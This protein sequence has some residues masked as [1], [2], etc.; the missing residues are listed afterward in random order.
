M[1]TYVITAFNQ[2]GISECYKVHEED[3]YSHEVWVF[4]C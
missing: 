3:D 2:G 4:H 1:R